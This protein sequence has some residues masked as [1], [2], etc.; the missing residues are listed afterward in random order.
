MPQK[1]GI[2]SNFHLFCLGDL[3]FSQIASSTSEEFDDVRLAKMGWVASKSATDQFIAL[4]FETV[5]SISKVY[6]ENV[7]DDTY[8][9]VIDIYYSEDGFMVPLGD[10]PINVSQLE[11]IEFEA[12]DRKSIRISKQMYFKT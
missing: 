5:V 12:R 8:P 11:V 3:K 10:E 7:L 2:V 1:P 4:K 9:T 6:L